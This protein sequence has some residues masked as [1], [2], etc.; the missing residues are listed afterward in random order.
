MSHDPVSDYVRWM[1]AKGLSAGLV[2]RRSA[3]LRAAE[4]IMGVPLHRATPTDITALIERGRRRG[5][6]D[7]TLYV[8]T[9]HLRAFY[10]WANRQ[11]VSKRNPVVG[12]AVPRRPR[13]LP[14]PIADADLSLAVTTAEPR[15]RVILCLAGLAGL[16]AVEIARL[17]RE[18][19]L[20]H[21]DRPQL[22]IQGKGDKP[23]AVPL[24][25]FLAAELH[26][27]GLPRRGPVIRRLDG[28]RAHVS[29]SLISSL[30]NDHLHSLGIPDT[31]HSLRHYAAT[32]LYAETKNIRL[33]Q[34]IL[35]H[36]SPATT[37]VYADWARE[38][39]PAAM[40]KLA[41][42]LQPGGAVPEQVRSEEPETN[43]V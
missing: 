9:G 33:V 40:D 28:K 31:L 36:A 2:N 8:Y 10:G 26:R 4:K 18:D 13:Y 39:A 19:V 20:D 41:R 35:G 37:A 6:A 17:R 16:R 38:D 29:P 21:V 27:Y 43:G 25:T 5:L 7:S 23:R 42:K 3:Q 12:A 30:A 24:S 14:R 22:L 1:R 11:G 32:T 15:T 34:D